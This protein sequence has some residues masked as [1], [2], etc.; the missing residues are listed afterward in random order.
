MLRGGAAGDSC[1]LN[2]VLVFCE[3]SSGSEAC[4]VFVCF[5]KT[6]QAWDFPCGPV[7]EILSYHAGN[8]SSIL[9]EN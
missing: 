8:S 5:F 1:P 3:V 9:I 2:C 6:A 4:P 7:A